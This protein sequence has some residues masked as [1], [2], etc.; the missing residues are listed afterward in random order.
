[1][2]LK[3][4]KI[5]TKFLLYQGVISADNIHMKNFDIK[6]NL[7]FKLYGPI[8]PSYFFLNL[9]KVKKNNLK[10]KIPIVTSQENLC[11]IVKNLIDGHI[12]KSKLNYH[13]TQT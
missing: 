5:D 6:F 3:T 9:K 4:N 1:M 10:D 7:I 8:I 13:L 11:Q 2:I 12:Q